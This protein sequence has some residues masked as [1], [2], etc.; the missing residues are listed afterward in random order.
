MNNLLPKLF[1]FA[2]SFCFAG[3][4]LILHVQIR[5][6]AILKILVMACEKKNRSLMIIEAGKS[7]P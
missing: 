4:P 7:Q 1:D 6:K 5:E 3:L 2:E